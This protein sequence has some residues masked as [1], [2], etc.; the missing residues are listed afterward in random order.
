MEIAEQALRNLQE[1]IAKLIH[2]E[3]R[4]WDNFLE[5]LQMRVWRKGQYLVKE[6]QKKAEE[7]FLS[8]GIVRVFLQDR[9]AK[10]VNI[11]FFCGPETITPYFIRNINDRHICSIQAITPVSALVFDA[12]D[13]NS[14]IQQYSDIREYAFAVVEKEL[15]FRALKEKCFISSQSAERLIFFREHFPGLEN[16]IPLGHVANF[17]GISQVSLSRL[18]SRL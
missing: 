2:R 15:R 13:F 11:N 7:I 4:N 8:E 17:L 16:H 12:N 9:E 14:L 3:L 6:N 18:R 5:L 10:E 1:H